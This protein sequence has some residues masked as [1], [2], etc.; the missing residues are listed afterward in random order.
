MKNRAKHGVAA[1]FSA[2]ALLA[3]TVTQASATEITQPTTMQGDLVATPAA[4]VDYLRHS[5]EE[6]AADALKKFQ[7][8]T[9]T[10]QNK[11]IDYLHDPALLKSLLEEAGNQG[12]GI[13]VYSRSG[14][15]TTSLHNG[16]VTIGQERTISGRSSTAKGAL[17]KGNHEAKYTTYVKYFGIK[18]IKLSLW[19][20]FHSNGR[21]ITKANHADAGKTNLSGAISLSKGTPKKS[22]SKWTRCRTFDHCTSGHNVDASVVWEGNVLFK[23]SSF[24]IDK[25]QWMRAG[26]DGKL[27]SYYLHNV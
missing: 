1:S 19:V 2:V 5:G 23:G 10:Q 12:G 17:P 9:K 7:R 8:L 14:K 24:Q 21:D 11:F 3:G 22:L 25:E 18:V 16:D 26:V 4:Y 15:S 13:S 6:G 27:V 20:N